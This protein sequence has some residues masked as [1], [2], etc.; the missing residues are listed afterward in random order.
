[1]QM[2][3]QMQP[4]PGQTEG[5][6]VKFYYKP[7]SNLTELSVKQYILPEILSRLRPFSAT[8]VPHSNRIPTNRIFRLP[9][10]HLMC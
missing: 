10:D 9:V 1:M 8:Q 3:G 4:K 7:V 5:P 6:W 2:Y